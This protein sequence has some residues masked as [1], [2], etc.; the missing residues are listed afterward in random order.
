M[1]NNKEIFAKNAAR[2]KEL[3]ALQNVDW[4]AKYYREKAQE[5]YTSSSYSAPS[6][7]VAGSTTPI[8]IANVLKHASKV[9]HNPAPAKT[10]AKYV[11]IDGIPHKRT[12]DGYK[13][14]SQVTKA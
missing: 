6:A 5:F 11:V 3:E 1:T 4:Q 10:Y 9:R 13:P 14:L 12:G 7:K 2:V 8:G